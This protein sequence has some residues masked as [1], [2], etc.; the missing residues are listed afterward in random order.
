MKN[1][2]EV[3]AILANA[4]RQDAALEEKIREAYGKPLT[5]EI[6]FDQKRQDWAQ[7]SPFA[8]FVPAETS[9]RQKCY[10]GHTIGLLIGIVDENKREILGVPVFAGLAFLTEELLPTAMQ[11]IGNALYDSSVS[12]TLVEYNQ[13]NAPLFSCS[14]TITVLNPVAIGDRRI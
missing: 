2:I 7:I 12:I 14:L 10:D 13:E 3:A 8:V 9:L 5:V 11:A 4:L 1:I 6:G